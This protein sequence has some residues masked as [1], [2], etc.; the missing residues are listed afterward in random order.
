MEELDWEYIGTLFGVMSIGWLVVMP[1][2]WGWKH[3][4]Q[5]MT[6]RVEQSTRLLAECKDPTDRP[7]L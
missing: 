5:S 6:A 2:Y 3:L 1:M 4:N 7:S